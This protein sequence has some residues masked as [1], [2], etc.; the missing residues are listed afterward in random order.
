MAGAPAPL[1]N[2]LRYSF[3][4]IEVFAII[5]NVAGQIYPDIYNIKYTDKL[6]VSYVRGTSRV[7]LGST[8]GTWEGEASILLGKSAATLMK[9]IAGPGWLGANFLFNVTYAEQGEV[10]T[11]DRCTARIIGCDDDHSEGPDGLQSLITLFPLIP[12]LTNGI[13]PLLST[14]FG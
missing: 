10:F 14:P 1:I 12:T 9:T 8:A 5:N 13:P 4:S 2:G 6:S 11:V 3:A 7:P